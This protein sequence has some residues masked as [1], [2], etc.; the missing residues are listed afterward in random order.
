MKAP[1][2]LS[3]H[4]RGQDARWGFQISAEEESFKWFKLGLVRNGDHDGMP[5]P[6]LLTM[7]E[8]L[9]SSYNTSPEQLAKTYL[10]S[11]WD[12]TVERIG[13][14]YHMT[15]NDVL[16]SELHVVV[17]LPAGLMAT[18][19]DDFRRIVESAG[20]PGGQHQSSTLEF[21]TE[22]EAA[23]IA[24]VEHGNVS[25]NLTVPLTLRSLSFLS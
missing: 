23:A 22:A 3:L 18:T 14:E 16:G 5:R 20:I 8:E 7:A 10:R 4:R 1:T 24:L 11:L 12:H 25:L 13:L 21:C 9:Q 17:G 6:L 2:Q 19:R 15:A